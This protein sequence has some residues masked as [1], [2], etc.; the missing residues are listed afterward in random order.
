M[1]CNKQNFAVVSYTCPLLVESP[2][3]CYNVSGFCCCFRRQISRIQAS[4]VFLTNIR[5]NAT[6]VDFDLYIQLSGTNMV[7][8]QQALLQAVSVCSLIYSLH[9]ELSMFAMLHG[10]SLYPPRFHI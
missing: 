4:D 7:L 8:N 2:Q 1:T 10:F 6:G 3:R 9:F 5:N